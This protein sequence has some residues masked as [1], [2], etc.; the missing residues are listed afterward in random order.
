MI[1]ACYANLG[2]VEEAVAWLRQS[3]ER[4]FINYP[5]LA[6]KEPFLARIRSEPQV[7]EVLKEVKQRWEVFDP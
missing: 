2:I 1:G 3:T 4:G 5:F 7:Q 6:E